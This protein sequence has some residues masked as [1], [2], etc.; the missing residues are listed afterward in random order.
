M[1]IMLLEKNKDKTKMSLMI[2]KATPAYMNS[3]RRILMNKVPTLAIEDIELRKN[4]SAMYDEIIAHRLGLVA[5]KTDSKSYNLPNKCKCEGKGCAQ[6]QV[7]LTLK[8]KGPKTVYASDLKSTDPKVVPV[9]PETPIT[10]LLK[11]QEL[12]LEATAIMGVGKEH[13]K[14]SPCLA[15]YKHKSNIKIT[16]DVEN[17]EDVVKSCPEKIFEIKK[18]KLC[19]VQDNALNCT[20][21]EQCKD[22]TNGI[23]FAEKEETSFILNI[24]SWGQLSV[25]EM[26]EIGIESFNETLD[27][28]SKKISEI[29]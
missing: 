20:L 26:F 21:C 4:S 24:D 11:N 28:L 29:K 1:E 6:C 23:V 10:K 18:N 14:W 2:K 19:V 9:F 8:V 7:K 22:L 3:I 15:F 25:K 27:E 12:E 13:V 5:L 17:K 16:K